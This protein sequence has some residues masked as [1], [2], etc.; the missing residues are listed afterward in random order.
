MEVLELIILQISNLMLGYTGFFRLVS[1]AKHYKFFI[2]MSH[3]FEVFAQTIPL[4]ML[5]TYNNKN[6]QKWDGLDVLNFFL[7]LV[8]VLNVVG[9]LSLIQLLSQGDSYFI[10]NR[11]YLG[12][13]V[14]DHKKSK[15]VSLEKQREEALAQQQLAETSF[16]HERTDYTLDKDQSLRTLLIEKATT[17]S[18]AM[19]VMLLFVT[20]FVVLSNFT[21]ELD[22]CGLNTFDTGGGVCQECLSGLGVTCA[23]CSSKQACDVCKD[24]Y[25]TFMNDADYTV[26]VPC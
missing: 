15:K 2:T 10:W 18:N 6:L 26:C 7:S 22:P 24:G 5:Q 4:I 23:E 1:E 8:N 20:V 14:I 16:I 12:Y 11:S 13:K 9:E 19:K 17:R 25:M 3:T 21:Y